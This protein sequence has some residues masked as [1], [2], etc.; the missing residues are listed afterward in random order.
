MIIESLILE[1]I[2]NFENAE[3]AK[4]NML[5]IETIVNSESANH[6]KV[7][8]LFIETVSPVFGGMVV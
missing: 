5:T 4:V 6:I 3:E 1:E 8:D 7:C 2:V